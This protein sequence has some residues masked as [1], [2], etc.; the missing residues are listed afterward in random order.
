MI[1]YFS[2]TG[3]SAYAAGRIGRE[4]EDETLDLFDRIR[5][6]DTST[7]RSERPWVVVAPTYGWRVPRVLS[8]WLAKT[9]LDGARDIY[10]VLTCGG[11]IG[12]AGAYLRSLCAE[13]GL[14]FRGCAAVIMPENYVALYDVPGRAEALALIDRAEPVIT[15]IARRIG[16]NK[17]LPESRVRFKDKCR[18]GLVNAVY[19]PALV[20]AGKFRAED[21]CIGCGKCEQVCPLNN[22]RLENGRPRWGGHCT[23]CMACICRCPKEAIEYGKQSRGKPRYICPKTL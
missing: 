21:T 3:N 2:G 1:L 17:D 8:G 14:R 10:F 4:I 15:G 20:H 23:H 18:S 22:I 13:K 11:S 6:Q 16:Q 19:Y 12:N 9:A 5:R 7:L